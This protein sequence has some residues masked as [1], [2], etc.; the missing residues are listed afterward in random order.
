M[1]VYDKLIENDIEDFKDLLL[2]HVDKNVTFYAEYFFK[3]FD[4]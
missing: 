2:I 1:L 4:E 3:I